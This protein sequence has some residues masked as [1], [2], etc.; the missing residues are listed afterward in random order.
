M[1]EAKSLA[2]SKYAAQIHLKEGKQNAT[3]N[4]L[5]WSLPPVNIAGGTRHPISIVMD[6]IVDIFSKIGFEVVEDR[7]IEDDWHNFTALNTPMTILQEICR[8]LIML[9]ILRKDY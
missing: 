2:E 1:N 6:R 3:D 4:Q 5:D 9:G 7:E 8:I